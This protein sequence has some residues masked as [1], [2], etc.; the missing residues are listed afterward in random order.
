MS[1]VRFYCPEHGYLCDAPARAA[2]ICGEPRNTKGVKRRCNR[3]AT[4]T[5]P[6]RAH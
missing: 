1:L 6:R 3:K 2:V 4:T 5:D